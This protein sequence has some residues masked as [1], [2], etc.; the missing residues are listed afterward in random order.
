MGESIAALKGWRNSNVG[1]PPGKEE[2]EG[3]REMEGV[4]EARTSGGRAT[5]E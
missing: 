3:G 4:E 2:G 5:E 1:I